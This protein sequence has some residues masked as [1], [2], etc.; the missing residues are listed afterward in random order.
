[1]SLIRSGVY[2]SL[3]CIFTGLTA[4]RIS[5]Y[6]PFTT[7]RTINAFTDNGTSISS[8][9]HS[10]F[11]RKVFTHGFND[12]LGDH[13]GEIPVKN[14]LA[15][16]DVADIE[17]RGALTKKYFTNGADT[18]TNSEAKLTFNSPENQYKLS[19][20]SLN[21]EQ[22]I[23][24]GF[25]LR[26]G[27]HYLEQAY[28]LEPT[29]DISSDTKANA[30]L[31]DINNVLAENG[32]ESLGEQLYQFDM[33]A[34]SFYAGWQGSFTGGTELLQELAGAMEIGY[35]LSR[36]NSVHTVFPYL[37]SQH[38]DDGFTM[39]LLLNARVFK[40]FMVKLQGQS[41]VYRRDTAQQTISTDTNPDPMTRYSGPLLLTKEL[42][43]KDPGTL[44]GIQAALR[45]DNF[46]AFFGEV[47]YSFFQQE[48]S[49]V[50]AI[51]E[52]F[53]ATKGSAPSDYQLSSRNELLNSDPRLAGWNHH[54]VYAAAGIAR[55]PLHSWIVPEMSLFYSI[56]LAGRHSVD[57]MS[58]WGGTAGLGFQ[59]T[60]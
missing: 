32:F 22:H 20:I 13:Y 4:Q 59:W 21:I 33:D 2:A 50:I 19:R 31:A 17:K 48:Q 3:L 49:R 28:T 25:Y 46:Y 12:Y 54:T 23:F 29:L 14:L 45:L 18:V 8:S 26:G 24:S 1:M 55:S 27:M 9:G 44:W 47:G 10:L 39:A 42:V 37:L 30:F 52:G 60:F 56:P 51:E 40:Y 58:G 15:G 7:A 5:Q 57:Y 34:A 36:H 38:T 43:K 16:V 35:E 6:E 11:G 53:A 41:T